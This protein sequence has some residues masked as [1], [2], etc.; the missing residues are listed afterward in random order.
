MKPKVQFAYSDKQN[1]EEI[2][3]LLSES[4]Y[5]AEGEYFPDLQ[6]IEKKEKEFSGS[7]EEYLPEPPAFGVDLTSIALIGLSQFFTT[8]VLPSIESGASYDLLKAAFMKIIHLARNKKSKKGAAIL[9]DA[10]PSEGNLE[11][12]GSPKKNLAIVFAIAPELED[13]EVDAALNS[14]P[15]F[16]KELLTF[17]EKVQIK[18]ATIT[19]KYAGKGQWSIDFK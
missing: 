9:T 10:P 8:I 19:V 11:P 14:M 6:E 5:E 1:E 15:L 4:G 2:S 7:V 18:A 16:R 17:L 12:L 13:A 3:S